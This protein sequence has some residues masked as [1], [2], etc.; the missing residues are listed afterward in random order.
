MAK[1]KKNAPWT[2]EEILSRL[3]RIADEARDATFCEKTGKNGEGVK[4]YDVKC[5]SVELKAVEYVVKLSGVLDDDRAQT[6]SVSI[7][8]EAKDYA[9]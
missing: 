2:K 6:V 4:E 1:K 7:L 3:M 5:A 9:V 8:G